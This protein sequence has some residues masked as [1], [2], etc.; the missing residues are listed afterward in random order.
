[1]GYKKIVNLDIR[2]P[3]FLFK[4][5]YATEKINGTSTHLSF[6][7]ENDKWTWKAFSGGIKHEEFIL[8]LNCRYN[9]DGEVIPKL[10]EMMKG[11]DVKNITIYGEGYGG[12]CQGMNNVY[13]PLNFIA[14]EVLKNESWLEVPYAA[15]FT[16]ALGLPFVHYEFGPATIEWLNEQRDKPSE[17]AKRNGMGDDKQGEGIVVRPPMELYDKNGGRIMAKH[18]K[19]LFRETKT[20]RELTEDDVKELENAEEI[21][22]E[23]VVEERLNHV[24]SSLVSK[25]HTTFSMSDTGKVIKA[26]VEDVSVEAAG[27]IVWSQQASQAISKKTAQMF[28]L[29]VQNGT[30]NPIEST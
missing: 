5:V 20:K 28:K 29:R 30:T 11:R 12:K 19:E 26:M 15:E 1:M 22:E 13:G 7:F 27:K 2:N 21:A 23:W 9:I 16:K 17:Q 4:N 10:T 6:T 3:I 25:G 14:F 8:M 24:L 18:K